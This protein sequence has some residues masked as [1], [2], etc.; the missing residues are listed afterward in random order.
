[1]ACNVSCRF[2]YYIGLHKD[3]ST[4]NIKK[5]IDIAK[6]YGMEHIDF[7]GGE[8][9]MR[10]D[11]LEL[12]SYAKKK[13]FKTICALTNGQKFIDKEFL[14]ECR[15]AG[16]NE[17]LFSVHGYNEK[18]HDWLTRVPGSF[19]KLMKSIE[20]AKKNGIPF[21]TNTTVTKANYKHLTEHAK[22][23]IK[24]KPIQSNF[25]LFNDWDCAESVAEDFSI[26]YSVASPYLKKAIDKMKG[27]VKSINVRYIPFCFMLGY[28]KY[29]CDYSQKIYDPYE[30]SQRLLSKFGDPLNFQ[31]TLKHYGFVVMGTLKF[32]PKFKLNF[33]EYLEDVF[34][35]YRRSTYKKPKDKCGKCKF[36]NICDGLEASYAKIIGTDELKPQIGEKITDPLF[37]RKSGD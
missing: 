36:N 25:I 31:N 33:N 21:R 8:P 9:T 29:V 4:E 34:L 3:R 13:G 14:K 35:A 26:K 32:R 2:C 24:L 5:Q 15:D 23:F 12:V 10:G 22:I 28:E 37:F 30:W 20:N 18:N 16:L 17:I 27:H 6:K 11:F 1:M 19:N 7:S